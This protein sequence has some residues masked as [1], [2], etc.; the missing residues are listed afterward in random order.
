ML[1]LT[2]EEPPGTTESSTGASPTVGRMREKEETHG[3]LWFL[4][5]HRSCAEQKRWGQFEEL[6]LRLWSFP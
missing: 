2:Q 3:T 1:Y 4:H 5:R 6:P